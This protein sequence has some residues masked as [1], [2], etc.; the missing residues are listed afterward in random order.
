MADLR[1]DKQ[2][3]IDYPGAC[4]ISTAQ[5]EELKKQMGAVA[6]VECSSKTQ[7]GKKKRLRIE[8]ILVLYMNNHTSKMH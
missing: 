1:E 2:F 5:G 7:Q 8:A 4:T 6:Y 3:Q